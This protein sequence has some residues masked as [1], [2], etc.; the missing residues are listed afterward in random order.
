MSVFKPFENLPADLSPR[1]WISSPK[2]PDLLEL[3]NILL[4]KYKRDFIES[5]SNQI[6]SSDPYFHK[7]IFD[8]SMY[9]LPF[10]TEALDTRKMRAL[11]VGSGEGICSATLS[12][13]F[14]EYVGL[15]IVPT[16]I[17]H[18][19][20]LCGKFGA[21][22]T[23]FVLD[24]AA[25][26]ETF[27]A[28]DNGKFDLIILH[29]V[30]EHLLPEERF[31]ALRTCWDYLD[32]DGYLFIGEAPNNNFYEDQHSSFML[33]FQQMPI[34]MWQYFYDASKNSGWRKS[35]KQGIETNTMNL[36]AFRQG[37]SLGFREF[38]KGLGFTDIG[39]LRSYI[40]ADNYDAFLMNRSNYSRFDFLKLCELRQIR[41]F[42]GRSDLDYRDFPDFFS[43]HYLD[44]LLRKSPPVAVAGDWIALSLDNFSAGTSEMVV[45]GKDIDPGTPLVIQ[46]PSSL[47]GVSGAVDVM[48]QVR[49][50]GD[51]GIVSC[52]TEKGA[53]VFER[54]L[55]HS[56]R[57]VCDWRNMMVFKLPSLSP[58][59]FPLKIVAIRQKITLSYIFFRSHEVPEAV[60]CP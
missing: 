2:R 37:V 7:R 14:E 12:H 60:S 25:N 8:A 26:L 42:A 56:M 5:P 22:N 46:L 48:L 41:Q 40:V 1:T 15:E 18:A 16:L 29:A 49:M 19:E 59:D 34:E 13:V 45:E 20:Q 21:G 39:M 55:W 4:Q 52:E 24:E 38:E 31:S 57:Q 47:V 50:P 35:I 6:S 33:Y 32:D 30:L 10:L 27:L 54:S 44:V 43:R 3:P 17:N 23:H 51:G 9:I 53:I 11:E 58:S 28:R 36:R